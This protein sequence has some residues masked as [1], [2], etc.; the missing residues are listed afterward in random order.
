VISLSFLGSPPCAKSQI[1]CSTYSRLD[2]INIPVLAEPHLAAGL[3]FLARKPRCQ[4]CQFIPCSR[5]TVFKQPVAGYQ[6]PQLSCQPFW[7]RDNNPLWKKNRNSSQLVYAIFDFDIA[8]MF[9]SSATVA[10]RR[11][12][13]QPHDTAQGELDYD[14]FAFDVGCLGILRSIPSLSEPMN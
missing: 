11:L 4:S 3:K 12:P 7:C 2:L 6:A 10:E 1:S 5:Y 13:N 14:P 8:I 9:S